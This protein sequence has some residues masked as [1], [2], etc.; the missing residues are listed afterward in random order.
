[1]DVS[2]F[3]VKS[4]E[5]CS[6]I[7]RMMAHVGSKWAPLILLSLAG[8]AQRFGGLQ[9]SLPG[10]SQ[11]ILTLTLR[12]MERD[13]LVSRKV[14]PSMPPRVDYA[15]TQLGT[16]L[17]A[18]IEALGRWSLEHADRIAVAHQVFDRRAGDA[19]LGD[20]S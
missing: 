2:G 17:L 4:S 15:I 1:M 12:E 5:D 8:T 9:R 14:T 11:R 10:I 13:G 18:T 6:T 19:G 16:E 3:D 20:L 7:K